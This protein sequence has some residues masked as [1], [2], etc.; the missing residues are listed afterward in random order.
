MSSPAF[1]RQSRSSCWPPDGL[2][3]C[4]SSLSRGCMCERRQERCQAR[5]RPLA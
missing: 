4:S 2:M 1:P 5:L 3:T